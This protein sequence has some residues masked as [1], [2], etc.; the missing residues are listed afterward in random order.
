MTVSSRLSEVLLTHMSPGPEADWW[1]N[2][3]VF[4]HKWVW[5]CAQQG[6]E[7]FDQRD[8]LE[9]RT[10]SRMCVRCWERFFINGYWPKSVCKST[11]HVLN[12]WKKKKRKIY[13]N[14]SDISIAWCYLCSLIIEVYSLCDDGN[15]LS[16]L[17]WW[18]KSA[19]SADDIG[20]RTYEQQFPHVH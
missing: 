4:F 3:C 2:V 18:E 5:V 8:R 9:R 14:T 12:Q 16:F 15:I 6:W 19:L 17:F 13:F 20:L 11:Q 7:G 10:E 1:V